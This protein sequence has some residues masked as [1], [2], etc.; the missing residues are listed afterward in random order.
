MNPFNLR[1]FKWFQYGIFSLFYNS[2]KVGCLGIEFHSREWQ[3][4]LYTKL[5]ARSACGHV[6]KP[7]IL[8]S[9]AIATWFVEKDKDSKSVLLCVVLRSE[10]LLKAAM[11]GISTSVFM[12]LIIE[13][14][15]VNSTVQTNFRCLSPPSWFC[16]CLGLLTW[17]LFL[18][19]KVKYTDELSLSAEEGVKWDT[20][21]QIKQNRRTMRQKT[22]F[23][24]STLEWSLLLW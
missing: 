8:W 1:H 5:G 4:H 3:I 22:F 18:S 20:E 13:V 24:L 15:F 17:S 9:S 12:S 6:S 10:H 7:Q 11:L 23:L 19:V 2:V 21:S 14:G 16:F